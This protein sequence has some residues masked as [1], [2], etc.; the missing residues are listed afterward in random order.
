[1]NWG[2]D[3]NAEG[4][5]AVCHKTVAL[6]SPPTA[7]ENTSAACITKGLLK[8][9]VV[10]PWQLAELT[11]RLVLIREN[12]AAS[13]NVAVVSQLLASKPLAFA[14]VVATRICTWLSQ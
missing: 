14:H 3:V 12:D 1:M 2:C 13:G 10:T 9:E 7:L 5:P 11:P 8:G 6:V 4:G